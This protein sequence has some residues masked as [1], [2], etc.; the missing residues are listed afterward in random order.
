MFQFDQCN[1]RKSNERRLMKTVLSLI[2]ALALVITMLPAG[3]VKVHAAV[4]DEVTKGTCGANL[5]W[6]LTVNGEDI[7][8]I[9]PMTLT[10]SGMGNMD[11]YTN[12]QGGNFAPWSSYRDS[13]TEISLPDGITSIGQSAF[14]K[15]SRLTRVSI[16]DS[17]T[18]I[19][20]GAFQECR[21]LSSVTFGSG[22]TR[23]SSV[24]FVLC[25]LRSVTI[26]DSV[27][28][29]GSG[30]FAGNGNLTGVNIGKN[31]SA[32]TWGNAFYD[33]GYSCPSLTAIEVDPDNTAYSTEDG[34]LFNK[35][36]TKLEYYPSGKEDYTYT[37]P[38]TVTEIRPYAFTSAI[39]LSLLVV[40]GNVKKIGACAFLNVPVQPILREGVE[41]IESSTYYPTIQFSIA[42]PS[43]YLLPSSLKKIGSNAFGVFGDGTILISG[44]EV[45]FGRNPFRDSTGGLSFTGTIYAPATVE[46]DN[47]NNL[48][49][50]IVYICKA[51]VV[52]QQHHVYSG[53]PITHLDLSANGGYVTDPSSVNTAVDKGDYTVKLSLKA[54]YQVNGHSVSYVWGDVSKPYTWTS[55]SDKED[56]VY[57]W[58]IGEPLPTSGTA[59]G[60]TWS[61]SDDNKTLTISKSADGDGKLPDYQSPW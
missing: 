52:S 50:N 21:S 45:E 1:R 3:N 54:D 11:T 44:E 39:N 19:G 27:D 34:V 20:I 29:I 30:A 5:T 2:T 17:V 13:I 23:I 15:C 10:I 24:A 14:W 6:A 26:P 58:S 4:G 57:D 33:A 16:P 25:G 56:K 36:K 41:E 8:G 53:N 60:C 32:L 49:Y 37:I 28:F 51:P 48:E 46:C 55:A 61:L 59:G 40:P 18:E 47:L 38:D 7:E 42:S 22:L 35:H 9:T 43:A 31:T 12:M